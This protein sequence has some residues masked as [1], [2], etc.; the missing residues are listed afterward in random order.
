MSQFR[1]IPTYTI[2]L[3]Q[4]DT[5]TSAWYRYFQD[6]D[7]GRPPSGTMPVTLTGS[8]FTIQASDHGGFLIVAGGTVSKIEFS[9]GANGAFIDVGVVA[10]CLPM[11]Q[12]DNYRITYTGAPTVTFVPM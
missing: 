2:P 3:A 4:K 1:G 12:Q 5:T 6:L 10:G 7:S 8:P 11:G 9:R